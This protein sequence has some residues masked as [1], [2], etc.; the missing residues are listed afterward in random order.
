MIS[1]KARTGN[2]QNTV[3]L[4]DE[5]DIGLHPSGAKYLKNEL[6]EISKNNLVLFSTHSIFMIDRENVSRHYIVSKAEEKTNIRTADPSNVSEEEVIN[7]ALGYSLFESLKGKNILF[8]GWYDKRLFKVAI[9]TKSKISSQ[10]YS[11]FKDVGLCHANGLKDIRNIVPM[12][13]TASRLC[14]ILSDNDQEAVNHQ[15]EHKKL[16]GYGEWLR[17][18]ELLSTSTA[19]T[20]EDFVKSSAVVKAA[21]KILG[22]QGIVQRISIADLSDA[23]GK[24]FAINKWLTP[25][26][27]N[28]EDRKKIIKK[29]KE[30]I[31]DGLTKAQIE[32]EYFEMIKEISQKIKSMGSS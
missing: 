29:I 1:A 24:L 13:E 8:E 19:V 26:I 7:K 11:A 2:L 5:P 15:K 27:S 18:P 14:M 28:S 9:S 3:V 32:D 12:F 23:K 30:T 25:I 31:F 6:I 4:I 22:D 20:G 17:Y 10:D 21:N 16:R